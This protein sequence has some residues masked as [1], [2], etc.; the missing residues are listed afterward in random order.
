VDERILIGIPI[1]N[2]D[3]LLVRCLDAIDLDAGVV[4]INNNSV[5]PA[6][7]AR[8]ES[9]RGPNVSIAHQQR[10]LGVAASW[11]LLLREARNRNLAQLI[12]GSNDTFLCP[13]ALELALQRFRQRPD[14]I[15][16]IHAWNFFV[17]PTAIVE[18][19]GWFDENFYPAYKEDQDYSYRC[20]LAGVERLDVSSEPLATHLG[21]QT[22]ASDE[23]YAIHNGNTHFNWNLA[24][25]RM[26]WGGDAGSET[27]R[28]PYNKP[29][30]DWAWWPDPEGS[31]EVR[32]WD[33]GKR[34][35][36]RAAKNERQS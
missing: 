35:R 11:N 5:D 27:Y 23:E 20:L 34:E 24:H 30:K 16:H 18:T 26:K 15:W 1:L 21:S 13:G 36:L 9:L 14:A 2:R 12:V 6:L 31:I 3:D 32:D 28:T 8:V 10:N 17:A 7:S 22:I 33:N 25:Y 4:V 19:V 29:D